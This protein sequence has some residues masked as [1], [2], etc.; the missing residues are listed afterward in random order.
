MICRSLENCCLVRV[1]N[2]ERVLD[3]GVASH[4]NET[5]G[6]LRRFYLFRCHFGV[7]FKSLQNENNKMMFY[8]TSVNLLNVVLR[9]VDN[10]MELNKL[11]RESSTEILASP[12][13]LGLE[14]MGWA[15]GRRVSLLLTNPSAT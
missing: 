12:H 8:G 5:V 1:V 9:R 2:Y 10:R 6:A 4:L 7:N 3:P 11:L 13:I 15:T 14:L